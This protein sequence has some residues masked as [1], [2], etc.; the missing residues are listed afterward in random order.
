MRQYHSGN[1]DGKSVFV[2]GSNLAGVH[3]A[4]AARFALQNCG[5]VRGEGVGQQGNSYAIPTKDYSIKTL[6]LPDVYDFVKGFIGCAEY[7][8]LYTGQTFFVTA[9][10]TGLAGY[11]HADIAPMFKNAPNNCILPIEWKEYVE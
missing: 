5:A 10:G 11:R 1:W 6:P 8:K 2:F 3:G 7:A 4:G 9:I